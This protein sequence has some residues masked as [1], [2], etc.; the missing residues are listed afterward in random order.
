MSNFKCS[1]CNA[2]TFGEPAKHTSNG[3]PVCKWCLEK[4]NDKDKENKQ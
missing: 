3:K 2:Y 1:V 4:K